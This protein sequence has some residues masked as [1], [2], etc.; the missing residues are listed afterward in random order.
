[1]APRG[2]ESCTARARPGQGLGE[3]GR[4]GLSGEGGRMEQ[5]GGENLPGSWVAG[6]SGAGGEPR[7]VEGVKR[8]HGARPVGT[9]PRL[10]PGKVATPLPRFPET[11]AF[12]VFLALMLLLS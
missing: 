10:S 7:G 3:A 1:M 12:L 8:E 5:G 2:G 6:R 4:T 9:A 11:S